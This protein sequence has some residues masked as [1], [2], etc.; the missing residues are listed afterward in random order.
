VGWSLRS[1]AEHS[2]LLR[3]QYRRKLQV[4]ER[5][6]VGSLGGNLR[7]RA[8]LKICGARQLISYPKQNDRH[9]EPQSRTEHEVKRKQWYVKRPS[10]RPRHECKRKVHHG[11]KWIDPLPGDPTAYTQSDVPNCEERS[12]PNCSSSKHCFMR[13]CNPFA[14]ANGTAFSGTACHR[15]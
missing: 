5:L 10:Q 14:T 13:L 7:S 11:Q 4:E 6:R 3:L 9:E 8:P 2:G 15:Q 12:E 1:P